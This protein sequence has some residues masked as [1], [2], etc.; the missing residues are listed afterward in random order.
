MADPHTRASKT[1]TDPGQA[2]QQLTCIS[3]ESRGFGFVKMETGEDANACIEAINGTTFEG[4]VITV[5]H[6]SD[7]S[8]QRPSQGHPILRMLRSN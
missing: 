3:E 1:I 4:K 6:V 7:L 5:A 8:L 2:R